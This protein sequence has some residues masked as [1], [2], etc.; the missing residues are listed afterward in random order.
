MDN[1][2][3]TW[4]QTMRE[5]KQTRDELVD[6]CIAGKLPLYNANCIRVYPI[7]HW[8][9]S[10]CEQPHIVWGRI[11]LAENDVLSFHEPQ[12]LSRIVF[13]GFPD[14]GDFLI[15]RKDCAPTLQDELLFRVLGGVNFPRELTPS[16][17][18]SLQKKSSIGDRKLIPLK[19]LSYPSIFMRQDVLDIQLLERQFAQLKEISDEM[20]PCLEI[21]EYTNILTSGDYTYEIGYSISKE[22]FTVEDK[23]VLCFEDVLQA[24]TGCE[25]EQGLHVRY[26]FFPDNAPPHTH[27]TTSVWMKYHSGSFLMETANM[28]VMHLSTAQSKDPLPVPSVS[29]VSQVMHQYR[30]GFD[31]SI[32]E[33][34]DKLYQFSSFLAYIEKPQCIGEQETVLLEDA[35]YCIFNGIYDNAD[36]SY[37]QYLSQ[38]VFNISDLSMLGVRTMS[39]I[40]FKNNIIAEIKR[41]AH[42]AGDKHEKLA[43]LALAI[44]FDTYAIHSDVYAKV[45]EELK[46]VNTGK[47]EEK[48]D[49]AKRKA[50]SAWLDRAELWAKANELALL[51][52]PNWRKYTTKQEQVKYF[53][54]LAAQRG[55]KLMDTENLG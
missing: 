7:R 45:F 27:P 34:M 12:T 16:F 54:A 40:N 4:D 43:L 39:F 6:L 33:H 14:T 8:S 1:S 44:K 24:N 31:L 21:T 48:N 47:A 50:V 49:G 53:S 36:E 17:W 46:L 32:N 38:F 41:S 55:V 2:W 30:P 52:L 11:P 19:E 23:L 37:R 26:M 13:K 25:S 3:L 15:F 10:T 22:G 51:P 29:A 18:D 5:Y 42:Q 20:P 9:P 28:P 35:A